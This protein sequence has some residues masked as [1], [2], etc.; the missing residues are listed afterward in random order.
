MDRYVTF[1]IWYESHQ[2][3]SARTESLLIYNT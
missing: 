1:I 2:L 3:M